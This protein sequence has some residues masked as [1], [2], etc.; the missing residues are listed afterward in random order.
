[1][2]PQ[3]VPEAVE[4][5]RRLLNEVIRLSAGCPQTIRDGSIERALLDLSRSLRVVEE[6]LGP[7]D[8]V[9]RPFTGLSTEAELLGGLAM[10]LRLRMIQL[11]RTNVSGVEDFIRR[12]EDLLRRASVQLGVRAEQQ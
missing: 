12:L 9:R 3:D 10:A 7:R 5:A 11:G 2:E 6:A 4:R 1:M 8:V